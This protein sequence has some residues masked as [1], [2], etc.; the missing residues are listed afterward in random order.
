MSFHKVFT[1]SAD[2]RQQE[3]GTRSQAKRNEA[4]NRELT[5]RGLFVFM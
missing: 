1:G 3:I 4:A 2:F 5:T